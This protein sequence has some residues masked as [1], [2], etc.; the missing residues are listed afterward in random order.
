MPNVRPSIRG[1]VS[2]C[3]SRFS[4]YARRYAPQRSSKNYVD[5]ISDALPFGRLWYGGP[6]AIANAIDYAKFRSRSHDAE[7]RV[8]D[9]SGN[10]IE[11][12]EHT[13]DFQRA[14]IATYIKSQAM[15]AK[16]IATLV[17]GATPSVQ[18]RSSEDSIPVTC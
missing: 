2:R 4:R 16:A 6:D 5:L 3:G 14:S 7:I 8:Y 15:T 10:V 18:R 9:E 13:R 12:Y 17:N 1:G 11:T